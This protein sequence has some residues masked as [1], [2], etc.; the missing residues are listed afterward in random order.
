[1]KKITIFQEKTSPVV[2]DD[3]DEREIEE[4]S[5]D[6]SSLLDNSNVTILHTTSCSVI[7]RPNK[8]S[9]IVVTD[10]TPKK[11]KPTKKQPPVKKGQPEDIIT[12]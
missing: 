7:I 4:Y 3:N 1:M 5:K 10:D 11:K 9:S 8:V 12:D 6:L 2:V